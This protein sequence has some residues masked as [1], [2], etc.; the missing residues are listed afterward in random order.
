MAHAHAAE[1]IRRQLFELH[2]GSLELAVQLASR[3][4]RCVLVVGDAP[5]LSDYA[6]DAWRARFELSSDATIVYLRVDD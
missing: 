5:Y 1:G 6:G 2:A 3:G 4:L